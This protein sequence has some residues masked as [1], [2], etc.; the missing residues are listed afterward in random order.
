M[1]GSANSV[2]GGKVSPPDRVAV[3]L[4]QKPKIAQGRAF[5]SSPPV[6]LA[7][8]GAPGLANAILTST[9]S[10]YFSNVADR[11]GYAAS[12]AFIKGKPHTASYSGGF[13]IYSAQ[14]PEVKLSEARSLLGGWDSATYT[15]KAPTVF[16]RADGALSQVY[17]AGTVIKIGHFD[18]FEVGVDETDITVGGTE[19]P[20]YNPQPS[21]GVTTGA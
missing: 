4:K 14:A 21:K 19:M 8:D 12:Q 16:R 5:L 1:A 6:R 2:T 15:L 7:P 11:P 18:T 17:K 20:F 9:N 13:E 10:G 3:E